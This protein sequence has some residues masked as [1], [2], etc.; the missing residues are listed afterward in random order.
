MLFVRA[1]KK[2]KKIKLQTHAQEKGHIFYTMAL[3]DDPSLHMLSLSLS[4][5]LSHTHT[6]KHTP[7][8]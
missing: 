7:W 4:L 3:K 2:I 1:L 8:R 5:S 6:H